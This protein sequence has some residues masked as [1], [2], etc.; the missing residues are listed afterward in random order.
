[1]TDPEK[2]KFFNAPHGM[3][4]AEQQPGKALF[5]K[6]F[7][8]FLSFP[9]LLVAILWYKGYIKNLRSCRR[10]GEY[11]KFFHSPERRKKST[12]STAFSYFVHEIPL[13]LFP[14]FFYLDNI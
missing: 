11:Q 4:P 1:M 3:A 5:P 10:P 13:S 12:V 8:L 14:S 2:R 9:L 7:H 6:D